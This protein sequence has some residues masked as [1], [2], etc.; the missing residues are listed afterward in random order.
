M[1]RLTR[2]R[3]V[4]R[5]AGGGALGVLGL[6][7]T[8]VLGQTPGANDAIGVA[9]V[10]LHGRGQT[11]LEMIAAT[12]GLRLVGLC[13]VDP[14]VLAANVR[15]AADRGDRVFAESDVRRLLDRKDVDAVTIATPN[16]WHS[17]IGIWACQAGKDVYIEK[18][19]SHHLWEGRQLVHA[20]RKHQR[21]VQTGTQARANPDILDALAWLRAGNL[22]AIRH[23]HGMCY[24]PRMSIGKFGR[25]EIPPGLDYDLWTGPAPMKPLARKNLHYDWHWVYDYGNGDLGNQGIHEMDLA[26]WFLGHA[27]LARRVMSV[28]GRL[29]YDDDGETPNT[30]LVRL[31][32]DGPP[33]VFEVRGLPKS[34]EYQANASLW[35]QNMDAPAGFRGGRTIGVTVFCEGG[36]LVIDDGG[37]ALLAMDAQDKVIRRFEKTDPQRGIGWPK[38]D[39]FIFENWLAAMRSRRWEDLAA[40]VLEG[41]TSSALC[42]LGMISHRL[43]RGTPAEQILEQVQSD[44]LAAA[45]FAS[46]KE[47]LGRN[48]VDLSRGRLAFGPSLAFDP[49][50]EQFVDNAAANALL[51]RPDRKP[52]AVPEVN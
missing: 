41:H 36:R 21:I 48:G 51:R 47:H 7:G 14:A 24:K 43:G 34:R 27:G 33:L 22:G 8:R 1:S 29:G 4:G 5:L 50:R 44:A 19:V 20:A 16:H 37:E 42:H 10:G 46:M 32:Y 30:Q 52:F 15:K 2:R 6:G 45:E 26:R 13:D 3:F 40:D 39:R 18:P 25:G 35:G 31:A 23:A 9:V 12:K 28:G 49:D 17:L 38:G 11:H